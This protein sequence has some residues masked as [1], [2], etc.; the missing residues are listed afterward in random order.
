MRFRLLF[1]AIAALVGLAGCANKTN[2]PTTSG[3]L[4]AP[5]TSTPSPVG[6]SPAGKPSTFAEPDLAPSGYG[7]YTIGVK[8]ADL[9]TRKLVIDVKTT[10]CPGFTLAKGTA[11]YEKPSLVFYNGELAFLDVDTPLVRTTQGARVAMPVAQV[12]AKYP[13]AVTLNNGAGGMALLAKDSSG[14]YG[15]LFRIRISGTVES[16]EAGLAETIEFRFTEGEGC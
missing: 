14:K 11:D 4:P 15:L 10:A 2:G 16:I 8:L 9:K 12:Q 5:P 3:T 13:D 6:S 1:L 7:P